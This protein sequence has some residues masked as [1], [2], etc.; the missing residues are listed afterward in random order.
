MKGVTD[1]MK[2]IG[3]V[4]F[5]TGDNFGQRLQNLALQKVLESL[6][7]EVF[8]IRKYDFRLSYFYWW[9]MHLKSL[10]DS[11]CK[12]FILR[13]GFF[14]EFDKKNIKYFD[15]IIK[16]DKVPDNLKRKFDAFVA[17]SD[18]VW[19]PHTGDVDDF[20]FLT[21]ADDYQKY[22]YAASLATDEIPIELL[23][24]YSQR[25]SGFQRIGLRENNLEQ[26]IKKLSGTDVN[27]VLD[28][29]LLISEHNWIHYEKKPVWYNEEKYILKYFLGEENPRELEEF[30]NGQN[31]AVIDL[32]DKK[33]Q[34][35]ISGPSEFL[36]L[37][38]NA[39]LVVT[40]SFHGI[41]FSIIFKKK[42]VL[43]ER[44]NDMANSMMAR[45]ATL[46][47]FLGIS[48]EDTT[49]DALKKG[50]QLDYVGTIEEKLQTSKNLSMTFLEDIVN[51]IQ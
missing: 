11:K 47:G 46:F 16:T 7:C 39:E 9:K 10:V 41:I 45:F 15:T 49:F 30:A 38:H 44:K 6:D 33:S 51:Q 19:S 2:K 37:I 20:N 8:T 18:Q 34:S 22:S 4:T 40:D 27:T 14:L 32:L 29:T 21:F 13:H 12:A 35:Y 31:M 17:G 5:T 36:Y 25:L 3:I 43:V 48:I 28:P 42:F 1:S 50:K 23:E 26:L 24:K